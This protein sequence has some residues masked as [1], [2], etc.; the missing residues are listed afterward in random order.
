MCPIATEVERKSLEKVFS[1]YESKN[2]S[3][4]D[5]IGGCLSCTLAHSTYRR[6]L[7]GLHPVHNLCKKTSEE[8]NRSFY[9]IQ[10]F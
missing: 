9:Q 8:K 7:V 2:E 5:V 1:L 6:L 4:E 3:G 10:P